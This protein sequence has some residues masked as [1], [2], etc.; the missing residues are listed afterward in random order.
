MFHVSRNSDGLIEAVSKKPSP[1]SEAVDDNDPEI[2]QFFK[3]A[4]DPAFET[5]DAG[6]VRVLEDVIDALIMKNVIHHTDLP[7]AAQKKLTIRKGLRN[8]IHD[9]LDLLGSDDRIL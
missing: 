7:L 6:F 1:E 9:P 4:I 5:V 8:R 3:P 2:Q